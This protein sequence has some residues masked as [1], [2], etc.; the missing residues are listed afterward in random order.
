MSKLN[1][2]KFQNTKTKEVVEAV[3]FFDDVS[4]V[5]EIARWCSGNVRKGGR[6]DRELVTIMTNGSVYVATD[7][8]W[9]F[10]DS[11]GDFYPSENEVFRGIYEEVA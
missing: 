8:H 3:Y 9:I 7:E 5:D 4:D 6:F 10:K 11:R 1:V 2:R